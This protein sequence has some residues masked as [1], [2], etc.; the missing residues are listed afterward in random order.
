VFLCA[1]IP[2]Q[3]LRHVVLPQALRVVLP[4]NE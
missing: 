2:R 1:H 3:V 4:A